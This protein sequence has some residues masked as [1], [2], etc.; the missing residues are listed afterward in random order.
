[1]LL[2]IIKKNEILRNS[3]LCYLEGLVEY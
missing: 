3:E 2:V 1:M